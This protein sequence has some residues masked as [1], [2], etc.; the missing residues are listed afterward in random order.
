MLCLKSTTQ[1]FE[2]KYKNYKTKILGGKLENPVQLK[3]F[4]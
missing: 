2:A 3:K 1:F 4:N